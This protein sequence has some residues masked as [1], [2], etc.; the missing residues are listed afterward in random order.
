MNRFSF[1][2]ETPYDVQEF[3]NLC[4]QRNIP[5]VM[6][7]QRPDPQ[8]ADIEVELSTEADLS[9]V[10]DVMFGVEDGHVMHQTL[11]ACPLKDNPLTRDA[12]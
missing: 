3:Q 10:R 6:A 12:P 2:A 7:G 5:I 4:A 9:T 8:W 1:R 11:R